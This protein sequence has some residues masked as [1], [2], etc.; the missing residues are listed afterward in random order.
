MKDEI[1]SVGQKNSE[2]PTGIEPMTSQT[3]ASPLS[4]LF[5]YANDETAAFA[6]FRFYV[7]VNNLMLINVRARVF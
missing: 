6:I 5:R 3:P 4:C 1:F 7:K 2:S